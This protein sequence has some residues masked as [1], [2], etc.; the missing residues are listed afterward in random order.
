[1]TTRPTPRPARFAFAP[2]VS[3]AAFLASAGLV[4]AACSGAARPDDV[5]FVLEGPGRSA[6]ERDANLA[7]LDELRQRALQN[8]DAQPPEAEPDPNALEVVVLTPEAPSALTEDGALK[9]SAVLAFV[10]QGPHAVLGTVRLVPARTESGSVQGFRVDALLPGSGFVEAGGIRVGDVIAS[11]NGR[12]IVL[13]DAFVAV[14][15][16]LPTADSLSVEIVR[17]GERSRLEW[18]IRDGI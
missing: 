6:G 11:V 4:G 13:P 8:A 5:Q 15:E 7:A 1:M 14:W 16:E 18:P 12:S 3:A 17:D 2:L 10:E 9:R